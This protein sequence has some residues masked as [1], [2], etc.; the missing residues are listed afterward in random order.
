MDLSRFPIE[1]I[2]FADDLILGFPRGEGVRAIAHKMRVGFFHPIRVG[3]FYMVRD[4]EKDTE[5]DEF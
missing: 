1:G 2:F 3:G 4:R 5:G